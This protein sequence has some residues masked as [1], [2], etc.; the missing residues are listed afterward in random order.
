MG[1]IGL[2]FVG[3][4]AKVMDVET[5]TQEMPVK[6]IGEIVVKGPQVMQGYWNH[7]EETA[8]VLKD[9]WLYTGDIGYMDEEG[10]FAIVD[11]KKDMSERWAARM[12]I[13]AMWKKCSVSK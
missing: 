1:M 7:P 3:T 9:G 6:G 5:G 8:M 4:D 13:P 10:F 11:R 12:F 2:P